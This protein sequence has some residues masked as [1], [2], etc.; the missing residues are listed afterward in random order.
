MKL[1]M[2]LRGLG[3][4]IIVTAL[5]LSFSANSRSKE[6][7]DAQIKAK[8]K[9]LGMVEE[10]A[11]LVD[12]SSKKTEEAELKQEEINPLPEKKVEEEPVTEEK[13]EDVPEEKEEKPIVEEK[14]EEPKAEEVKEEKPTSNSTTTITIAG[15]S[16]SDTVARLLEK[17]GMVKSATDFDSYLCKNG[18]DHRI[19]PGKHTI[20]ANADY[21]TIAKIITSK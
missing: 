5:I 12:A 10:G 14:K 18:Y 17:G 20:P 8:A 13:K 15:G 11:T 3:L 4:G 9:E 1:R 19:V 7:T 6:M 2:Y 21:N 16:S